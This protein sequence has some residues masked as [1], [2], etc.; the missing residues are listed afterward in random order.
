MGTCGARERDFWPGHGLVIWPLFLIQ[1]LGMY[2]IMIEHNYW[3]YDNMCME[4]IVGV[5]NLF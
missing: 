5:P 2:A 4:N 3:S 1:E